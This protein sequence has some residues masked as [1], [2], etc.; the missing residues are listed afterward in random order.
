MKVK[1]VKDVRGQEIPIPKELESMVK[2]IRAVTK[3]YKQRNVVERTLGALVSDIHKK[4][5]NEKNSE[6]LLA[7]A[8]FLSSIGSWNAHFFYEAYYKL[9][10]DKMS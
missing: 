3:N 6:E 9:N 4:L 2:E 10:P 8:T 7:M 5:F 1:F